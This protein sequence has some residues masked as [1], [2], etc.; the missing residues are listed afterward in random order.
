[1]SECYD[2]GNTKLLYTC[3]GC[4]DVGKISDETTRKLSKDGFG[5]M[6]CLAGI[7]ARISDFIESAK[8]ADE[9]ITID[10]CPVACAKKTLEGV[11]V[12]PISLILTEMGMVK[13]KTPVTEEVVKNMCDKITTKDKSSGS[14]NCAPGLGCCA[15]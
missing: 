12:K 9:N 8:G 1:M 3:S 4:A 14:G 13:G 10:G 11:E 5:K 7:G 6:T 2:G 15:G